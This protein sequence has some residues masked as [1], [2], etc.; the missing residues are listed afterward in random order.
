MFFNIKW[1]KLLVSNHLQYIISWNDSENLEN[2]GVILACDLSALKQ[3]CSNINYTVR[4]QELFQKSLWTQ[5]QC[6]LKLYRAKKKQNVKNVVNMKVE[7][8]SVGGQIW[9]SFQETW[10]ILWY[11]LHTT[12]ARDHLACYQRLVQNPVCLRVWEPNN[13]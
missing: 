9:N 7:N 10:M 3:H 13:A 11:V 5:F 8:C 6:R 12:E 4:T 2:L 1:W